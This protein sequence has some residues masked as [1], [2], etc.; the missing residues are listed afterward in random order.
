M[1]ATGAAAAQEAFSVQITQIWDGKNTET[2]QLAQLTLRINNLQM[3][4]LSEYGEGSLILSEFNEAVQP[5]ADKNFGGNVEIN[6][7]TIEKGSIIISASL[8]VIGGGIT[9]LWNFFKD[10]D[11]VKHGVGSFAKDLKSAKEIIYS[12][13]KKHTN[14]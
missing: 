12:I 8:L 4:R 13:I 10:Y 14:K 6:F 1:E 7:Y 11:A 2:N 5:I 9:M 3:P